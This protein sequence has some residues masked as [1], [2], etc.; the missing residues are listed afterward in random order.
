MKAIKGRKCEK[1][2]MEGRR[3]RIG[4]EIQGWCCDL[5]VA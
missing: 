3:R 5:K 2:G 1:G 4:R